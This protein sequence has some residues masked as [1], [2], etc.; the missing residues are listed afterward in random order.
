MNKRVD[1]LFFQ[2]EDKMNNI[3]RE[4][5]NFVI[6]DILPILHENILSINNEE[7]EEYKKNIEFQLK[8]IEIIKQ[9]TK[10]Y[11]QKAS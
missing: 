10:E 4:Y 6:K 11:Y 9:A 1:D 5:N 8:I 2:Y 7:N 3:Q